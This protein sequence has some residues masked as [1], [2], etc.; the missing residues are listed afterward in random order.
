MEEEQAVLMQQKLDEEA[1]EDDLGLDLYT[2]KSAPDATPGTGPSLAEPC[3]AA[4]HRLKRVQPDMSTLSEQ[5]RMRLFKEAHPE[6]YAIHAEYRRVLLELRYRLWPIILLKKHELIPDSG[7][8]KILDAK[9]RCMEMF[10]QC[11]MVYFMLIQAKEDLFAHP[12]F[13][14]MTSLQKAIKRYD[15]M[16]K[17]F[18]DE[19]DYAL[20]MVSGSI[21]E[22][23]S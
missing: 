18:A 9:S 3:M 13:K 15:E 8:I 20:Q 1:G 12:V 17:E 19:I 4:Y 22:L 6:Y 23:D 11:A 14:T 21:T 7:G 5:E 16:D 2:D 10:V